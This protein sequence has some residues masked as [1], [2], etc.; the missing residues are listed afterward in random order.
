MRSSYDYAGIFQR[1]TGELQRFYGDIRLTDITVIGQGLEAVV[2]RASAEPFGDVAIRLP[3]LRQESNE[4]DPSVDHRQILRQEAALARHL[5]E[6]GVPVPDIHLLHV[7]GDLDFLISSYVPHDDS[8]VSGEAMGAM[9]R[10]LHNCPLPD[11]LPYGQGAD[12][13]DVLAERISRRLH[14]VERHTGIAL[15]LRE[16]WSDPLRWPGAGRRILHMDYRPANILRRQGAIR[17]LVDWS[18]LLFGDPALEL[19]RVAE[20][21]HVDRAFLDGYGHDNVFGA[22][23]PGL[24]VLY[25]LDTSVMLAVVFLSE[26]PDPCLAGVQVRRVQE[27]VATAAE[28]V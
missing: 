21:G 7:D 13:P 14:V 23:P 1:L 10:R 22:L 4:N 20:Y 26:A 11:A 24:E 19:A 2:C 9:L 18:N 16:G 8:Q 15:H 5:K 6:H 28:G 17:A 3:W 12:L 25:R 27:L